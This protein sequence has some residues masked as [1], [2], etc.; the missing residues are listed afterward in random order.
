M[1]TD[2]DFTYRMSRLQNLVFDEASSWPAKEL[3]R[4][5]AELRRYADSLEPPET[6]HGPRESTD[7]APVDKDPEDIDARERPEQGLLPGFAVERRDYQ[8]WNE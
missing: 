5:A 1:T 6:P 4:L 8:Y 7:A 3:P 2:L